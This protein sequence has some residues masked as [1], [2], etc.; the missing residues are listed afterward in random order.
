[1][2]KKFDSKSRIFPPKLLHCIN[3]AYLF[4]L[5]SLIFLGCQ[6]DD[7]NESPSLPDLNGYL[8]RFEEEARLRGYDFD[9]S[10]IE[11]A[12]VDE[13]MGD[14][15]FCGYGYINYDGNGL[16]RIEISLAPRCGWEKRSD[17]ERENLFFHEIGHAF[18]NRYH[19]ESKL[20][21]GS[22]LSIMISTT[23]GWKIYSESEKE[24]RAYYISELIDRMAAHQDQ[25]IDYAR[26]WSND[27]VFYQ[28]TQ[29]DT[30]W[31]FVDDGVFPG[32]SNPADD[33]SIEI[34]PGNNTESSTNLY[35]RFDHPNIPECT[36][37]TLRVT[38]NSEQLTGT[39]AAISIRAFHAPVG[40]EGAQTEEYMFLTTT[41]NPVAGPLDN[42]VEELTIPCYSRNT[43][44]LV[45]F[46]RL[47]PGTEGKVSFEDVQLVVEEI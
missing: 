11:T 6:E 7:D 23:D 27:S 29:E 33:L 46:L 21:D 34:T 32:I 13:I 16:R 38:M 22:P 40:K 45:V 42:Y 47:M 43:T 2:D 4:S 10:G 30:A 31:F 26:S 17:I 19:D 9:L 8:Q 28:Y 37:V 25:C 35:K 36:E 20:C 15:T 41:E 44:Y 5:L 14:D 12:Y 3:V 24:K 39:G 1:M 18:F